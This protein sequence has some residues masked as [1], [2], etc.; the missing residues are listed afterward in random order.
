MLFTDIILQFI[1]RFTRLHQRRGSRASWIL[2]MRYI[3]RRSRYFSKRSP[4]T[5]IPALWSSAV[6][7]WNDVYGRSIWFWVQTMKRCIIS[8]FYQHLSTVTDIIYISR[9]GMALIRGLM[10]LYPC[11]I[12]LVP[13]DNQSDLSLAMTFALRTQSDSQDHVKDAL[14]STTVEAAEA[15]LK[16]RSLRPVKVFKFFLKITC[17]QDLLIT[18]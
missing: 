10:G 18:R 4:C 9:A 2:K 1:D 5:H 11:P 7:L 15:I 3:M 13:K 12:C 17:S 6:M 16:K 14:K 8:Q